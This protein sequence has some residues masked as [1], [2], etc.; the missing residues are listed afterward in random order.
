MKKSSNQRIHYLI[1]SLLPFMSYKLAMSMFAFTVRRKVLEGEVL[2][3]LSLILVVLCQGAW[4]LHLH[5]DCIYHLQGYYSRSR[6]S[7]P[8]H[9]ITITPILLSMSNENR[10]S[11]Y[12]FSLLVLI[13]L[14]LLSVPQR[15]MF[16]M[17]SL[18]SCHP[19]CH[20]HNI[21]PPRRITSLVPTSTG[22]GTDG[23][24]KLIFFLPTKG[25]Q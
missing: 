14:C 5:L 20:Q 4:S 8:T 24:E 16:L 2:F 25:K 3:F 7:S 18:S 17:L 19:S 15:L 9:T 23:I 22:N 11:K 13:M 6:Y 21:L 1:S 10:V 12:L